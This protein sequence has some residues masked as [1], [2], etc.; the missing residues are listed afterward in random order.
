MRSIIAGIIVLLGTAVPGFGQDCGALQADA[1]AILQAPTLPEI[2]II[3]GRLDSVGASCDF[4]RKAKRE[5]SKSVYQLA[6]NE[7]RAGT[8]PQDLEP[9]LQEARSIAPV[10]PVLQALAENAKARGDHDLAA[11]LA[12][13]ASIDLNYDFGIGGKSAEQVNLD[14][15]QQATL[16]YVAVFATQMQGLAQSAVEMPLTRDGKPDGIYSLTFRNIADVPLSLPI[17]FE[18]DSTE[19]TP[20]GE[21]Y[22][23]QLFAFITVQGLQDVT[24][25]GHTDPRGSDAYNLKLSERRAAAVVKYLRHQGLPDN[26]KL[27]ASGK[28]ESQPIQSE[29]PDLY[30]GFTEAQLHQLNRRVEIDLYEDF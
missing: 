3:V 6:V 7:L 4:R 27:T 11:Q 25:V 12:V 2:R 29:N 8:P 26:V 23:E 13:Q 1:E 19:F 18:D 14:R 20:K 24:L 15:Q 16:K 17:E 9:L 5:L 21:K 22:A 30:T 28:G 10:W